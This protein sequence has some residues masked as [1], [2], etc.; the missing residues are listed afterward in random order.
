MTD[1]RMA[2]SHISDAHTALSNAMDQ[3]PTDEDAPRW[4]IELADAEEALEEAE[5]LLKAELG[6]DEEVAA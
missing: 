5:R 4:F 1:K 2:L 6:D 3:A